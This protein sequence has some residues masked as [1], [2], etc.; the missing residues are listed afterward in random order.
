MKNSSSKEAFME[1]YDERKDLAPR[2]VVA[3]A[4]DDQVIALTK[5]V[6]FFPRVGE[7]RRMARL[8]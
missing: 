1:G 5:A 8:R 7:R 2:D 3:R 6:F 4:I